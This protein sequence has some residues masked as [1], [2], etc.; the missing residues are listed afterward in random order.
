VVIPVFDKTLPT[1]AA[2][3]DA[4]FRAIGGVPTYCLTDNEK[5]VTV[6]HV[7]RIAMRNPQ[8]VPIGRYYGT[9]VRTCM[10][11]DPESKGGSEA[12]VRIAKRDLVPTGVNLREAYADFASLTEA[13]EGFMG[14]VNG[15]VHRETRRVPAEMLAE[16]R[17]RLH[18]VPERAFT[19]VFGQSRRVGKDA[20]IQVDAVRYSVPHT[21]VEQNVWVRFHGQALIVTA[22]VD[23]QPV[24]VA[25]HERSTP[26]NPSID[27]AHYPED[28]RG[29]RVP[30]PRTPAE[31]QFLALGPGAAL[32]LQEAGECGVRHVRAKM[33]DAVTLAKL[34]G[35]AEVDRALGTAATVERFADGDLMAILAHQV[36]HEQSEPTRPG[37]EHSLQPGTSAWS[38]FGSAG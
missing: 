24:E 25:R 21:L 11:A 28:A 14:E 5:T 17:P 13:C 10:P 15:R 19:A 33:A 16:E 30:R 26:G 1:I 18:P 7:A 31:A 38:G 8:I 9:V 36:E 20:T 32:W 6:E 27:D 22:M 3:L 12:T 35:V 34:H 23:R 2:C 29:Q 4:T 37:E